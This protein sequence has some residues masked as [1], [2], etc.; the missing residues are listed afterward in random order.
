[1]KQPFNKIDSGWSNVG[2]CLPE[3]RSQLFRIRLFGL[4]VIDIGTIL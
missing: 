2:A 1:M 3:M 4:K